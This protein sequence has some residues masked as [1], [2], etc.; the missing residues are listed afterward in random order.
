MRAT[1]IT[2]AVGL[3]IAV[4]RLYGH[5]MRKILAYI[6]L[7]TLRGNGWPFVRTVRVPN[8]VAGS[9]RAVAFRWGFLVLSLATA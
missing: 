3:L 4:T 6:L 9:T 7:T 8:G 5:G 1:T 2:A